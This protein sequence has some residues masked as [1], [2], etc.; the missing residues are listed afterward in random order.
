M[1]RLSKSFQQELL[2]VEAYEPRVLSSAQETKARF[3]G[4]D[5]I[6][7][8]SNNYLGLTTNPRMCEAAKKAI[9]G[10]GLGAG[11]ARNIAGYTDL[12]KTLEERIARFKHTDSSLVFQSG[13]LAN[14]GVISTLFG[15]DEVIISDELNH[16]S[17]ID[18]CRLSRAKRE[19]YLHTDMDNLESV[20]KRSQS[21]RK[22]V[23]VTDGVFSVDGDIAP[24]PAIVGLAEKYE[25]LVIVD[26]AHATGVLGP[27]G[28]GTVAHFSLEGKVDIQIGTLSKAIGSIGGYVASSRPIIEYLKVRSRPILFSTSLPPA[29]IA[30]ATVAIDILES[31]TGLLDKLWDNREFFVTE[32][33]NRGFNIG[34]TETP[35]VPITIGDEKNATEITRLLFESGVFVTP[36]AYPVVPRGKAKLRAIVRADHSKEQLQYATVCLERIGHQS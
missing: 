31:D 29:S 25:A 8:C 26:D 3:D 1:N 10:Y 9:D 21:A 4:K 19:V 22:R 20:L 33:Q 12:Y 7:L 27:N 34:K 36:L 17:I 2:T 28:G 13:F 14:I 35:I 5:V 15:Q 24:L 16:G 11:A 18:G 6:N 32:L 23:I 30:C